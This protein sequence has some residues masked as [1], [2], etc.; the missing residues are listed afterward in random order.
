MFAASCV[1]EFVAEVA[2]LMVREEMNDHGERRQEINGGRDR[3]GG[4][5]GI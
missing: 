5:L 1:I 2:V 3:A 4:R